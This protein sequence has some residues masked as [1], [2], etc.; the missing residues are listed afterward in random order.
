MAGNEDVEEIVNNDNNNEEKVVE[1]SQVQGSDVQEQ[2]S[3]DRLI[4][5]PITRIKHIIKTD[6][7][8]NL[9]SS[10]AVVA[11]TKAAEL[12]IQMVAKDAVEKTLNNK[13]KTLQRKDLDI[14]LETR[15]SYTFLEG[16]LDT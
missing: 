1:E 7:D 15:D 12:F 11:L 3:G 16:A 9:A 6:P 2:S 10:E 14:V 13:R 4:R 8:V 5:L